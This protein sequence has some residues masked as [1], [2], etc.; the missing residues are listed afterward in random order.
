LKQVDDRIDRKSVLLE[1]LE[2]PPGLKALFWT[3]IISAYYKM[4]DNVSNSA[5]C[6]IFSVY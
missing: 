2:K 1:V 3:N 6:T 4:E 5:R